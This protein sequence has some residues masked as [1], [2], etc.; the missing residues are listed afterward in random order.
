[1]SKFPLGNKIDQPNSPFTL[2]HTEGDPVEMP[3]VTKLLNRKK[4][5]LKTSSSSNKAATAPVSKSDSTKS[6]IAGQPKIQR[7]QP[8]KGRAKQVK[9][10]RW[11]QESLAQADDT[12]QKAVH[13]LV[14]KGAR[15]ALLLTPD[16][17]V[18]SG[19]SAHDHA[20]IRFEALCAYMTEDR[21]E[22]WSGLS[23]SPSLIPDI[24]ERLLTKG[25]FEIVPSVSLSSQSESAAFLIKA[26]GLKPT[27]FFV[28]IRCGSS[29][30]CTG[31]LAL[32]SS[33]SLAKEI[34]AAFSAPKTVARAA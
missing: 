16:A 10:S 2:D 19:S 22:L 4:L 3:S 1:M 24:W 11:S 14:Q 23:L 17:P 27:E 34:A 18:S 25:I 5:G 28:I 8:R 30:A 31:L 21:A 13:Y 7:V 32:V 33:H 29:N 6:N 15:Q 12:F 26:F 9:I 20:A